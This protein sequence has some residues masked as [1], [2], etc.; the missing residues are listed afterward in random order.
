MPEGHDLLKGGGVAA[1]K[2][3]LEKKDASMEP[4]K[5]AVRRE[6]EFELKI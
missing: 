3:E 2:Q 6:R 4:V 5:S 1:V